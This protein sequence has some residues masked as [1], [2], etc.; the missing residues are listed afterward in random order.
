M[1]HKTQNINQSDE[2][3][4]KITDMVLIPSGSFLMGSL[5]GGEFEKPVHEVFLDAFLLD[6]TLVT[7]RQFKTFV[8]E[9]KY[10]TQAEIKGSAWGYINGEFKEIDGF[11]WRSI[12]IGREEHPVVLVTWEDAVAYSEWAG[13]RLPTEAEWEKA[14]QGG[15]TSKL[16]TW[17]NE[18]PNGTQSN[19][20]KNP[21]YIPPTTEVFK[22]PPNNYG[23]YDLVGNVWQWCSDWYAENYYNECSDNNPLG[24]ATGTHRAR[25]GGAW[26]V[27]QNFRLRCSNRGAADPTMAVPNLG[28]RCAKDID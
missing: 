15:L 19:F 27:I 11:S 7:N 3:Y 5:T 28:F 13:K 23:I 24:P 22:F 8:Q 20:A 17:G 21:S 1:I 26:N 4:I 6:T 2:Q 12:A 10:V 14:A 16:Y 9:T 18:E 25:R